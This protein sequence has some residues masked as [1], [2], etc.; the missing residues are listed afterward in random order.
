MRL[1]LLGLPSGGDCSAAGLIVEPVKN[2]IL[3][4]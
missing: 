1:A 3:V 4:S 2:R